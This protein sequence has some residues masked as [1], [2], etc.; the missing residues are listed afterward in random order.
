[1]NDSIILQ[2]KAYKNVLSITK[3]NSNMH[4]LDC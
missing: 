4:L 2:H 3:N 1:M